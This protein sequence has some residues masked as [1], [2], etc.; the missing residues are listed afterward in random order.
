M[1]KLDKNVLVVS[2]SSLG[3]LNYSLLQPNRAGERGINVPALV[4]TW[5]E[6]RESSKLTLNPIVLL[7]QGYILGIATIILPIPFFFPLR[8]VFGRYSRGRRCKL[9]ARYMQTGEDPLVE[10]LIFESTLSPLLLPASIPSTTSFQSFI[11]SKLYQSSNSIYIYQL[12]YLQTDPNPPDDAPFLL[13]IRCGDHG[14]TLLKSRCHCHDCNRENHIDGPPIHR[15]TGRHIRISCG[16]VR[17]ASSCRLDHNH[18]HSRQLR[19]GWFG[20]TFRNL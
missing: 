19:E 15:D 16:S 20:N 18:K 2:R 5:L 9:R 13:H 6:G 17:A 3:A 14:A 1:A 12:Q 8:F 4:W 7:L 10:T 11:Q